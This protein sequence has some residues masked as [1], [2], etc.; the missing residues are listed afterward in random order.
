MKMKEGENASPTGQHTYI[1]INL[2]IIV[3]LNHFPD[4]IHIVYIYKIIFP[5]S[6]NWILVAKPLGIE[7]SVMLVKDT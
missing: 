3:P 5:I 6:F 2:Q 4:F 1:K 7:V